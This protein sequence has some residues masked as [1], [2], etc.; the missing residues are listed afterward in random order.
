MTIH[1]KNRQANPALGKKGSSGTGTLQIRTITLRYQ[2][3]KNQN[4]IDLGY[5]KKQLYNY[6]GFRISTI[7]DFETFLMNL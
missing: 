5:K 6:F 4:H 3:T 1:I 2:Y 7:M